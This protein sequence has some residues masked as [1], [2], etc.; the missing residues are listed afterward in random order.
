MT[1]PEAEIVIVGSG[2]GGGIAAWVLAEA[3]YRVLVLEKGPWLDERAFSNDDIKFGYRDLVT[4]DIL[5]EPRTFRQDAS[6]PARVNHASSLSR[7]VGGGTVHYG[8]ASF[9]FIPDQFRMASL[10]GTPP[11]STLVDWPLTYDELERHYVAVEHGVGIAGLAPGFAPFR[12]YP[13]EA[14][15]PPPNALSAG[16]G[17]RYSRQ[18]PMPPAAQRYEGVAFSRAATALGMHPYPTPCAVNTVEGRDG[19]HACVNCGYCNGWGCPNGSKSSTLATVL[20]RAVATGRCE[21]RPECNVIEVVLN[22]DGSAKSVL[23][24]DPEFNVQEQPGRVIVLACSAVDTARL[25]LMSGLDR[26]DASGMIGHNFTTHHAPSAV[27]TITDGV[28]AWDTHRAV[29]NTISLDDFQDLSG[30]SD[31]PG[32]VVFPRAGV[33][34]CV[35]NSPGYPAGTG[36]PISLAVTLMKPPGFY[37]GGGNFFSPVG[38]WGSGGLSDAGFGV[39]AGSSMLDVMANYGVQ[40]YILGV[41][42]DL[43]RDTN[44]V[45]LDPTV[46]DVY[47]MP[48]ARITYFN[49]PNDLAVADYIAAQLLPLGQQMLNSIGAVGTTI[50]TP[51]PITS[52]AIGPR[53]N[54]HQHGTMRMGRDPATSV[55]D[56]FGRVW[57]VPNLFVADGSL[58][59][60]SGGYNP[61]HTLEALAH[62]VATH[63]AQEGAA[64]LARK[65]GV[66]AGPLPQTSAGSAE[67]AVALTA[68]ATAA[69]G[70]G[71]VRQ[72]AGHAEKTAEARDGKRRAADHEEVGAEP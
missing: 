18:Y 49:H 62:W 12:G 15:Q 28:H 53:Y 9:R 54:V 19:R 55:T 3:G 17:Q 33:V 7:M 27:V 70:A 6:L 11:G 52:T 35:G 36:G 37:S 64:L 56:R 68:A 32:G 24:V 5:I 59:P 51:T 13:G 50:V 72:R 1:L 60:T 39:P 10:Y 25:A 69:A 57:G 67:T 45:D 31:L 30:R 41:A 20:K 23:Y 22:R 8:A 48:V 66:A 71:S 14:V 44:M 34:S 29:W 16:F 21:I 26:R 47:G 46:K 4:Q 65:P 43:P 58:F 42:E 61:T 63:I 2:A 40:A 38:V